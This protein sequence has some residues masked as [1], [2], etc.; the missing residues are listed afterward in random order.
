MHPCHPVIQN[1]FHTNTSASDLSSPPQES[2]MNAPPNLCKNHSSATAC[3]LTCIR[4]P[5]RMSQIAK[6]QFW[7]INACVSPRALSHTDLGADALYPAPLLHWSPLLKRRCAER[8]YWLTSRVV[9]IPCRQ[10]QPCKKHRAVAVNQATAD[11]VQPG[12]GAGGQEEE[13]DSGALAGVQRT[14]RIGM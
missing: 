1:T 12:E 14:G 13:E 10:S 2:P 7:Y 8:S 3:M 5:T 9:P 6:R 4:R 11:H